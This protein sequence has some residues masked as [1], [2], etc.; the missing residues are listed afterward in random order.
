MHRDPPQNL[1][2]RISLSRLR[3]ALLA[4]LHRMEVCM[5]CADAGDCGAQFQGALQHSERHAGVP[6]P[7]GGHAGR[8]CGVGVPPGGPSGAAERGRA[9]RLCGAGPATAALEARQERDVQVGHGPA[10]AWW[11]AL[12]LMC[13]IA[14]ARQCSAGAGRA[15]SEA[16]HVTGGGM[17]LKAF[18]GA[19]CQA[20]HA[21][22][23]APCTTSQVWSP[24]RTYG[25]ELLSWFSGKLLLWFSGKG[26]MISI[27]YS[28]ARA[29]L[30]CCTGVSHT[31][32]AIGC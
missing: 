25:V 28:A 2:L 21:T 31:S 3:K 16:H 1:H 20:G 29:W 24:H 10:R 32:C 12:A 17:A 23:Y 7:A 22:L 30:K 4:F 11:A 18:V 27:S 15:S 13:I 19:L 5:P 14:G 9:R 26:A 8:V 6:P